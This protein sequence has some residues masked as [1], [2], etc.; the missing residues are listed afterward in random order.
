MNE[1]VQSLRNDITQ[2]EVAL[3]K[4][5]VSDIAMASLERDVVPHCKFRRINVR[6]GDIVGFTSNSIEP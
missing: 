6:K 2:C 5:H 4:D 1:S 3:C